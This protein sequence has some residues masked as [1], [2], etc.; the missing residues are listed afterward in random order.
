MTIVPAGKTRTYFVLR[1]HNGQASK[2]G[3]SSTPVKTF[4]VTFN[5]NGHG[6]AD[7]TQSVKE[8]EVAKERTPVFLSCT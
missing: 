8:P 6:E 1:I 7:V 4:T 2:V 5:M 3:E